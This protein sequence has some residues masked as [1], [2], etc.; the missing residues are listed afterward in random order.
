MPVRTKIVLLVGVVLCAGLLVVA[1]I[2]QDK[3]LIGW[4]VFP[5]LVIL[6]E[7]FH[8]VHMLPPERRSKTM[9]FFESVRAALAHQESTWPELQRQQ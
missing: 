1:W 5:S 2:W 9:R 4:S 7:F 8:W 3:S 6:K